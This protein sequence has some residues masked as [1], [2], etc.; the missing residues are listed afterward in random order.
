M[1]IAPAIKT[2][3][4]PTSSP[5]SPELYASMG[6]TDEAADGAAKRVRGEYLLN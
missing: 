4:K 5:D 2:E 3:G 6:C 1:Y